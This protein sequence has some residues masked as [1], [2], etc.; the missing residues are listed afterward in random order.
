MYINVEMKHIE[1]DNITLSPSGQMVK[2]SSLIIDD[3]I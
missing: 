2:I 3:I 1:N